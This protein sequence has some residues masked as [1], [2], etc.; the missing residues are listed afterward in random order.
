[1]FSKLKQALEARVAL[2]ITSS[3]QQLYITDANGDELWERY[4]SGF[5][6]GGHPGLVQ[7]HNCHA[8]KSFIKHYGNIVGIVNNQIRSIWDFTVPG[9]VYGLKI[10]EYL[11]SIINMHKLIMNSK[12]IDVFITD[13][14][15]LGLNQNKDR[16]EHGNVITWEHF[17]VKLPSNMVMRIMSES[18]D[19]MRGKARDNRN[20]FKRGLEEISLSAVDT[21]LELIAQN[22][23]YRGTE[24]LSILKLFRDLKVLYDVTLAELKDNWAWQVAPQN[25]GSVAQIKNTAIGTLLMNISEGM[26]LDQAVSSFERIMAPANYKRPNAIITNAMV[27]QAEKTIE[28]LGYAKSLGRRFA[29]VDD[30]LVNNLLFVDRSLVKTKGGLLG[31]L[32]EEPVINPKSLTRVEEISAEDFV[33][34]VLLSATTLE[35]LFEGR[36]G[37]NLVSLIAPQDAQAPSMFK[38]P[39]GFSWSYKDAMADSIKERV[40]AAGGNVTGDVRISLSWYNFDDLDLHLREPGLG[41]HI[42]YSNR[43]VLSAGQGMLDVDMN[44]GSGRTREGVENI[45]YARRHTML[46]GVHKVYVNQFAQRESVDVGFEV[47]V[48]IDG[49]VSSFHYPG[50]VVGDVLVC[51]IIWDKHTKQF[52]INGKLPSDTRLQSKKLWGVDTNKF[53]RVSMVMNSPNAWEGMTG[54]LHTFFIMDQAHNDETARGF[55]NEFLKPDLEKH[56]RVFEAL[57]SKMTVAPANKQVSGLGFSST[58]HTDVIVKVTGQFTRMLKVKF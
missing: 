11:M 30:V 48:E 13:I 8:C 58:Q 37:G 55:F 22:S 27:L 2:L 25:A 17:F 50:K 28:E 56:K 14:P 15:N 31:S 16:D 38:W 4:L 10:P 29:T 7:E 46:D 26:E 34:Y 19:T 32:K 6:E 20:V 57:G 1:M 42:Y 33:N 5:E 40:K 9:D 54:N 49:E 21:V 18:L 35:V 51:D 43:G 23:L 41:T 36:H 53:Q 47:E 24:Y 12:I 52:T 3:H 39:N 45:T 44:A